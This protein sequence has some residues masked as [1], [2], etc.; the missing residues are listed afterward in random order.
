MW[1]EPFAFKGAPAPHIRQVRNYI[2]AFISRPDSRPVGA[3]AINFFLG[4]GTSSLWTESVERNG[5]FQG[6]WCG[7][8][9]GVLESARRS[10]GRGERKAP[11]LNSSLLSGRAGSHQLPFRSR[12]AKLCATDCAIRMLPDSVRGYTSYRAF[13]TDRDR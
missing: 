5:G 4:A 8:L 7:Q 12:V 6:S 9:N 3:D 2:C 1:I 10:T 11:Y 13:S